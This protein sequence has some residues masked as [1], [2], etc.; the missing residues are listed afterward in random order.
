M[1]FKK[2]YEKPFQIPTI[3]ENNLDSIKRQFAQGK[4]QKSIS[5]IEDND[6]ENDA[7]EEAYYKHV[8]NTHRYNLFSSSAPRGDPGLIQLAKETVQEMVIEKE[9]LCPKS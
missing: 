2:H 5:T 7:F 3:I 4:S 8:K 6:P 9:T 1:S